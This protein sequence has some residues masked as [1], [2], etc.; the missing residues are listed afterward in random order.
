LQ[1]ALPGI[2]LGFGVGRFEEYGNFAYEY[3]TGRP[4]ILNQPIVSSSTAGYLAAIQAA[5]D[6]TTPGYGGDGPETDIEALYQ[7]VTGAGFDGNNNG[8]VFD[9]GLAGLAST[10]LSPGDS[11]DVPSFASF[12]ADLTNSILPAEGFIGGGGFRPGALPIILTATDIGFAYQPRGETTITGVGG[13]TLPVSALSETS[14]PTTPFDS[15][16]GLQQTI[17]ALNALGALVIGLGTNPESTVDPRQGLEA[18]STLTGAVNRSTSTIANGTADPIAPGDPL[19]FQIASGFSGSVATGVVN[20]IQSAATNVAVDITVQA[21]DPR[22]KIVNHSGVRNAI[23]SGQIA[24]FEVEFIGDGVPRRFDLQFVRAGTNVVLGS[25]PVVIGTP[26]PGDGYEFTELEAGEIET[27]DDFGSRLM[28]TTNDLPVA[29]AASVTTDEDVVLYG[30]L[31]ATDADLDTLQYSLGTTTPEHGQVVVNLDGSFT[32]APNSNY[33]GTD[34][35]SFYANDGVGNSNQAVI[36]IT[37]DS[38]NDVPTANFATMSTD[39]DVAIN[40]TLT[41]TDVDGAVLSFAAGGVT[42]QHGMVVVN[43]DGSFTYTPNSNYHGTDSFSFT[44]NDGTVTSGEAN[45]TITLNAVNDSP[46]VVD[47][48]SDVGEDDVLQGSVSSLGSDVEGNL[49]AYAVVALPEHGMVSLNPD[50]TFTYT[51]NAN[52]FG[53][54]SFTFRADDGSLLSNTATFTITVNGV[55][56]PLILSLT[57]PASQSSRNNKPVLIDGAASVSDLDTAVNY[58]NARIRVAILSGNMPVDV[59]RSQVTLGIL[60]QGTG[61]GKLNTKGS[62]I[63]LNGHRT[64]IATFTG[65][66]SGQ[67]LVINFTAAATEAAVN[68]VLKQVSFKASKQ[69]S[70]GPRTIGYEVT[71][72]SQVATGTQQSIVL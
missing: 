49:L 67:P 69:A 10:Q 6:R 50:G 65:G 37:V 46:V 48:N 57:S 45:V 7:L 28:T 12:Q 62:K 9:S 39:E 30:N 24:T 2:D 20:A 53:L 59:R 36:T 47:G 42:P 32:Y 55:D 15:G 58:A 27:D 64:A 38:V 25:I 26:I 54:D 66:K 35:F 23:G 52:F 22:V 13:V 40:G 51:P 61:A 72:G 5:L 3:S 1:A 11:G 71:A 18:L 29:F 16:A 43:L 44:V 31:V 60:N 19:Y 33:H 21:S 56:D 34:S 70:V 17:T 41:G 8:S 68:A 63:Y 14:R 4:F